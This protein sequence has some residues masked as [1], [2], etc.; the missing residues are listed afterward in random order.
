MGNGIGTALANRVA[1]HLGATADEVTVAQVDGFD[2]LEIA[3]S[4]DPYTITQAAQDEA[5]KNTRWVPAISSAT[6]SSI[7]A[8]VG[9]QAAAEA[10]RIIFRFGLWP[11]ALALWGLAPTDPGAKQWDEA[12]WQGSTL[13]MTG[14]SPLPLSAIAAMAHAQQGVTGAMAHAFS[15]WAW[16]QATFTISGQKWSADIDALAVRDGG[17]KFIRH[18]R[19]AVDFPPAT[20]NRIGAAFSSLCGTVVRIEIERATPLNVSVVR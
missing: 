6:S 14:L 5:A 16:S 2:A 7:G 20:Y 17:G 18:D 12:Y 1:L 3:T 9:T 11:A 15:R 8:H 19:S 4:G 10:A 13:I